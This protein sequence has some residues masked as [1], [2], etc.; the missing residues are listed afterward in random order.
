MEH[1]AKQLL[2]RVISLN[3]KTQELDKLLADVRRE[4]NDIFWSICEKRK[5]Q[6]NIRIYPTKI[7]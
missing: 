7:C 2:E 1:Y 3:K 5:K 6:K 4:T